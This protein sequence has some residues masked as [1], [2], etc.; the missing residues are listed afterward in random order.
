MGISV[1]MRGRDMRAM[2]IVARDYTVII[3][4]RH[5]N[6]SSLQYIGRPGFYPKPAI[7]K[8]KTAD[9]DPPRGN[10]TVNGRSI[11]IGHHVAGLV[12]HPGFQ[13]N[14]YSSG[15]AAKALKCWE[16]TMKTLLPAMGDQRVDLRR[17]DSWALWGADH[18]AA[19]ASRWRWRIDTDVQSE[20]FGCLQL[21]TAEMAWSYIHGD[22]DL[23]DVI[24]PGREK[25]NRRVTGKIDGVPNCV[26]LLA[27]REFTTIQA[28]LNRRMGAEMVQHGAEAQ[29]AGHGDEPIT[30]AYPNWRHELLLCGATVQSWYARME[31]EL[32]VA[33][34]DYLRDP[35]RAWYGGPE[36][37]VRRG[38]S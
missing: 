22:Y 34:I 12:V 2:M 4:V 13:P 3:L 38:T 1:G 30:V 25:E 10:W 35:Q 23:K 33:S 32:P 21:R 6:E 9:L 15:K 26:P 28:E 19:G 8:A 16:D 31:R 20:H 5:T 29:Y 18:I 24:V 17:P 27:G 36:G 11:T 7:V 14:C 37:L